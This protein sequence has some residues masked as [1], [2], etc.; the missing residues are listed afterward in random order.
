[1]WTLPID[2]ALD[3]FPLSRALEGAEDVCK[4]HRDVLCGAVAVLPNS[5]YKS[6][7]ANKAGDVIRQN[8]SVLAGRGSQ[9][10]ITVAE[11]QNAK[12]VEEIQL[13]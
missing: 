13:L 9:P 2:K 5:T 11:E 6:P 1:M 3:T 12:T 7:S 8:W 4:T 10:S